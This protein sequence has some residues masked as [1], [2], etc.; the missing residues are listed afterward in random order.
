M[1][2]MT[3]FQQSTLQSSLSCTETNMYVILNW[4]TLIIWIV[5]YGLVAYF[6]MFLSKALLYHQVLGQET[7]SYFLQV[8]EHQNDAHS[9]WPIHKPLN[10]RKQ[11]E[12]APDFQTRSR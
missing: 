11:F 5:K 9:K 6:T 7:E 1:F 2:L 10:L 3:L 12:G 8:F 4:T